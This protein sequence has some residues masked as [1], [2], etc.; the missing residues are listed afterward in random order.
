MLKMYF[1]TEV[2]NVFYLLVLVIENS[3][4]TL[5]HK[6]IKEENSWGVLPQT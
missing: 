4:S 3:W 2:K 1:L 6:K 5:F